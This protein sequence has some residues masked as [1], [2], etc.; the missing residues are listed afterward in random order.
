MDRD[1]LGNACDPDLDGD[2]FL[3]VMDVCQFL[4]NPD[5][6]D[7]D[8]DGA[9]DLCDNCPGISNSNQVNI[10]HMHAVTICIL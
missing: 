1:G 2:G 10:T 4:F 6:K 3:N 9:G 5:Q 8:K 7:T